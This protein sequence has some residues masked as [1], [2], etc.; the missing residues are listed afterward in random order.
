MDRGKNPADGI[1]GPE[2][3]N[4]IFLTTN[5]KKETLYLLKTYGVVMIDEFGRSYR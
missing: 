1:L 2:T 4:A 3:R 5:R